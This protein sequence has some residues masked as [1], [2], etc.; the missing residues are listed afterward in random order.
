MRA[1]SPRTGWLA[2]LVVGVVS[3]FSITGAVAQ[4]PA[5]APAP[6]PFQ[7]LDNSF[8]VEEAFNQ[9]PG[10]FQNIF[11]FTRVN[12]AWASAFV[13]EW[14]LFSQTHQLSYA[15]SWAGSEGTSAWGDTLLSYR[16]QAMAEG[17]G[18]PA[19]APRIGLV[20]P[21][22]S[23]RAGYDEFGLQFNLPFSKQAG[24]VYFHWN[25]GL[26]WLPSVDVERGSRSLESPFFAAS[27]IHRLAPMFHPM[28]ELVGHFDEEP[29][30]GITART[31]SFTLSP[32]A[33]GGWN[34]GTHQLI[35][36]F[37]VPMTWSEDDV[38]ETAAFVYFSYE[39]PFKK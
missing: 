17:P 23:D 24:D 37:A 9:E 5:A 4:P 30:D 18:R 34:I 10:V 6:D 1:A 29:A 26:I 33:R 13:Q 25:A 32:G 22:G 2:G 39:L 38:R 14:P 36:G 31:R 35:V 28:V 8:L 21:T 19:F 27:A 20:L 15:L 16:F 11:G 7:I 12:D 3:L